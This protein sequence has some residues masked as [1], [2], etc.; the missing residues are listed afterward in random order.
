MEVTYC[1]NSHF[2]G[3]V[4]LC[5]Y[6]DLVELCSGECFRK[7]LE[8]GGN[9][10]TWATPSCPEINEDWDIRCNLFRSFNR[11]SKK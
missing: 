1:A 11:G 5:V 9:D 10:S 3:D 7:P 8:Y 2:L 6:I 4:G